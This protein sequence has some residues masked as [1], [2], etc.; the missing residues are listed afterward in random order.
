MRH[1]LATSL[2]ASVVGLRSAVHNRRARLANCSRSEYCEKEVVSMVGRHN[3]CA[4]KPDGYKAPFEKGLVSGSYRDL[5]AWQKS[6]DLVA[7]IYAC[8]RS[9][10][11]HEQYGLVSQLRRAAVA[12]A[13]NITEG[14]GRSGGQRTRT[15]F[16]PSPV[17]TVR[18][19]DPAYVCRS[20]GTSVVR[21]CLSTKR[22][23]RR[24][25]KN[26]ELG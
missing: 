21:E 4:V 15:I 10:P 11:K 3:L 16:A 25:C 22:G 20:I 12:V 17:I 26:A 19:R 18:N 9:F 23:C 8:T 6:S 7:E 13:S 5:K 2:Q 1:G 14:K 24:D